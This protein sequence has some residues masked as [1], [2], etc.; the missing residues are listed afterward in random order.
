M[1]ALLSALRPLHSARWLCALG[2]VCLSFASWAQEAGRCEPR[3]QSIQVAK[4]DSQGP[5]PIGKALDWT[6]VQLRDI[7]R[8]R[9]PNYV[10]APGTGLTGSAPAQISPWP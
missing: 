8:D 9:W 10:G 2:L 6:T 7:W 3:I 4:A 1:R 5:V